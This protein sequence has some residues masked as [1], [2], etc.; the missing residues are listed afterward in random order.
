[1]VIPKGYE[2]RS[3]ILKKNQLGFA[4]YTDRVKKLMQDIDES[5]LI[6]LR[7][8]DGIIR[9]AQG[10]YVLESEKTELG[11]KR[12]IQNQGFIEFMR[13]KEPE[14][15]PG[16]KILSARICELED[17]TLL[18]FYSI[19]VYDFKEADT[20]T[21]RWIVLNSNDNQ[22]FIQIIP[23]SPAQKNAIFEIRESAEHTRCDEPFQV[24]RDYALYI[25]CEEKQ[26]FISTFFVYRLNLRDG[27]YEILEK[28]INRFQK[29]IETFCD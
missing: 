3:E 10:A 2:K 25:L 21:P 1:M 4:F 14:L 29:G 22:A 28:C 11:E 8:S 12:R 13:D 19:G 23:K 27:S 6:A 15:P 20:K 5:K 26:N 16:K 7:C 17:N 9:T 24:T 18:L